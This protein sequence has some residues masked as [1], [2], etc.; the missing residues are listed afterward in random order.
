MNR[1]CQMAM[2][3]H[4]DDLVLIGSCYHIRHVVARH[5]A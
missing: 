3:Y 4:R 1:Q 2:G 5:E